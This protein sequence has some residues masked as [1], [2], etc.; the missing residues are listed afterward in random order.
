M[1]GRQH[2]GRK[3]ETE[4]LRYLS[5]KGYKLIEKNYRCPIGEID[6]IMEDNGQLVF[7]EVRT[8]RDKKM[9]TPEESVGPQKKF[10]LRKIAE[11]YL[12]KHPLPKKGC[13][14]DVLAL[15]GDASFEIKHFISAFTW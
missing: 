8:K 1:E 11:Y 4:A 7:V 13:R 9:G 14:F 5:K 12:M 2:L 15:E 3:G 6:L 10:R